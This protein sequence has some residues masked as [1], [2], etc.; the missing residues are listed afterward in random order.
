M[1]P[2]SRLAIRVVFAVICTVPLSVL[3][4][5]A[6]GEMLVA[7]CVEKLSLESSGKASVRADFRGWGNLHIWWRALC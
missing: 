1:N 2:K 3:A 7:H 5:C 6:V 4:A